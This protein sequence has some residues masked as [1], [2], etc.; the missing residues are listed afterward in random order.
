[1]LTT[2]SWFWTNQ[3]LFSSSIILSLFCLQIMNLNPYLDQ[4]CVMEGAAWLCRVR[5]GYVGCG[6]AM[7][8]CGV[9]MTGCG[10]AMLRCGVA[11]WLASRA[12]VRQS[13]VRIPP[14]TPPLVQPRKNPGAEKYRSRFF[15]AQQKEIPAQQQAYQPITK[16]EYCIN[17][18]DRKL[19]K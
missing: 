3:F 2:I 10:V 17:T 13:R 1:M 4:V 19:E 11:M 7:L 15:P 9:A 5:R 12:A 18:E 6:V 16:D 14:G 8:G